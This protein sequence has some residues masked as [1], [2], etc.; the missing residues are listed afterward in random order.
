MLAHRG[1][2]GPRVAVESSDL[3]VI[4]GMLQASDMISAASPQLFQYELESCVLATLSVDL[5]GTGRS[6]G[7][8]RRTEQHSSPAARLLM[9]L[10]REVAQ[11]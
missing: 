3:S 4:R 8:V 7:I 10:V 1:L 6:I 2:A 9:R 5:P 11:A